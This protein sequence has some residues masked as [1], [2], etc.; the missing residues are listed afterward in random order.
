MTPPATAV[1]LFLL[2]TACAAPSLAHTQ[3]ATAP[4]PRILLTYPVFA[5]GH[6]AVPFP[7]P[8]ETI[9]TNQDEW[10]A[11]WQRLVSDRHPTPPLP[12]VDFSKDVILEATLGVLNSTCCSIAIDTVL[13]HADFVEVLVREEVPDTVHLCMV[14]GMFTS[15]TV[16]VR[17]AR[18]RGQFRFTRRRA[19]HPC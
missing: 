17:T 18:P 10:F 8:Q 11:L 5:D 1:A 15:P 12:H 16:V 9:V 2:A 3:S 4:L 19:M 13:V 14:G 6:V 7:E